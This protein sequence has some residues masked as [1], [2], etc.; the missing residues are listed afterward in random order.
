M[1]RADHIRDAVELKYHEEVWKQTLGYN[2][3]PFRCRRCLEYGHLFKQCP[4]NIQEEKRRN[5]Q[6]RKNKEDKEGF[7]EVRSKR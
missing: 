3:I 6:Q 7:Q 1:N 2:R 5:K 4:L